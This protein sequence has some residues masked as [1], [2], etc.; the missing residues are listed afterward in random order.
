VNARGAGTRVVREPRG[1]GPPRRVREQDRRG[2]VLTTLSWHEDGRLGHA[3][4][5]I[6]DDSWVM[7]E[8]RAAYQ[9][10]WG[11]CDRLWH[12]THPS[13]GAQAPLTLFES[14]DYAAVDRIPVVL[15]PARL[16]AG[17][18]A[19]VL[20][21]VAAL[22]A[23][24]GRARV[25]YRGPYPTE[26]L[27]LTLLESFRYL[28]AEADPLAAF[29]E[30][31][32]EWIPAPHECASPAPGVTVH[33]RERV[34]KVTWRGRAYHR[35]DWQGI[36]RH[37]PRRVR[38][39]D[40]DVACSLWALGEPIEDH[41]RLDGAGD[42]V[43]F[44]ATAPP[45]RPVRAL[46]ETV[47]DGVAA[48]VA[49]LGAPPLARFVTGV[50]RGCTLEWA[51]VDGDLVAIERARLGVSHGFR[52]ALRRRARAASTRAER[53]ALGLAA[54][55]E[56][57]HLVADPLRARAQSQLSTL[58]PDSQAALLAESSPTAADADSAE[59]IAAAVECLIADTT[60]DDA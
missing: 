53:L 24:A 23:D 16:P 44:V 51:T 49:A 55:T 1:S 12:A 17:A 35:P 26:Q 50:A 10:P 4:I 45:T 37:A 27:F 11:L 41:L 56:I 46:P 28:T 13:A 58:P 52:D 7:I 20:N 29:M 8:P 59:R 21:L 22:A 38:D 39:V 2:T 30:G 42:R 54:L 14:L 33:S 15:E 5:R 34:E 18:G 32:L 36:R 3:W 40:G 47:R 6:T 57:A 60:T 43:A 19:A 48:I 31:R 25:D 9:S